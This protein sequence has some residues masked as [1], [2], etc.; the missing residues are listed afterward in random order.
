[1]LFVLVFVAVLSGVITMFL[2]VR[3]SKARSRKELAELV[4]LTR[5]HGWTY[6]HA[7]VG[8]ADRFSGGAP[9]PAKSV[10]TR[11]Y[12]LVTG[13]Y[14]GRLFCCFEYRRRG[15]APGSQNNRRDLQ[16]FRVFTVAAPASRPMLEVRRARPGS[17]L[18]DLLGA[19]NLELGDPGF[20]SAFRVRPDDE[21]FA[22]TALNNYIRNWLLTDGRARQL[23]FRFERNELVPW[24]RG[25]LRPQSVFPALDYLC[26]VLDHMPAAVWR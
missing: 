20:D 24:Q 10:N 15:S 21:R 1:M 25:R 13:W 6:Q 8:S 14:R 11:I 9:F 19:A 4:E 3:R 5:K 17:A 22:A 7:E 26:D 12:D 16:Y 23:P 2:V 18:L